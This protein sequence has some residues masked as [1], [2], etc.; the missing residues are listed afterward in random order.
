MPKK[1]EDYQK[2]K[3]TIIIL[4]TDYEI[5]NLKGIEKYISR[6]HI[7]EDEYEQ[8]LAF[9]RELFLKDKVAIEAAGYDSGIQ[10]GET[11]K[12]LEIARNMLKKEISI[13]TIIECTGLTKEEIKEIQ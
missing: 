13:E 10:Q 1:S 7:S 9:K 6:W 4:F 3:K 8:D 5:E 2:T 12:K 11:K